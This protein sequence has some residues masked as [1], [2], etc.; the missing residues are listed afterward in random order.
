VREDLIYSPSRHH[1]TAEKKLH[2][3]NRTRSTYAQA[4]NLEQDELTD[5]RR[6]DD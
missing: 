3:Y 4:S 6:S 5:P 1:I 2:R